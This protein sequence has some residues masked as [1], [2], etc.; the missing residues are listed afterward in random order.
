MI[1][2]FKIEQECLPR[3]SFHASEQSSREWLC[4][5]V[6][7]SLPDFKNAVPQMLAAYMH[8]APRGHPR[9]KFPASPR[10]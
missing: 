7:L 9:L 1:S 4:N 8:C 6:I 10:D 3:P 2:I 5:R